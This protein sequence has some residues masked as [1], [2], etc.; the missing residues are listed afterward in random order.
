LLIILYVLNDE[1]EK[2][3]SGSEFNSGRLQQQRVSVRA[4][5]SDYARAE[6]FVLLPEKQNVADDRLLTPEGVQT[7]LLLQFQTYCNMNKPEAL[8]DKAEAPVLGARSE[9]LDDFKKD[10]KATANKILGAVGFF[11]KRTVAVAYEHTRTHTATTEFVAN[12]MADIMRQPCSALKKMTDLTILLHGLRKYI[13][14]R[15]SKDLRDLLDDALESLWAGTPQQGQEIYKDHIIFLYKDRIMFEA[16]FDKQIEIAQKLIAT[17]NTLVERALYEKAMREGTV[18]LMAGNKYN[19]Q[20][21]LYRCDE[22]GESANAIVLSSAAWMGD[23]YNAHLARLNVSHYVPIGETAEL[24]PRIQP[25]P[26]VVA[27]SSSQFF[28]ASQSRDDFYD[29]LSNYEPL[30]LFCTPPGDDSPFDRAESP[31]VYGVPPRNPYAPAHYAAAAPQSSPWI[32]QFNMPAAAP[33]QSGS[34]NNSNNDLRAYAP[35][36]PYTPL[37]SL[38]SGGNNNNAPAVAVDVDAEGWEVF[39][40]D[41]EQA[42]DFT[43]PPAYAPAPGAMAP[44]PSAPPPSVSPPPASSPSPLVNSLELLR[45]DKQEQERADFE[46]ARALARSS[47]LL[48]QV[49]A[50]PV[51][52]AAGA[53]EV[54]INDQLA[55]KLFESLNL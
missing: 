9:V 29:V 46:Y 49:Q 55:D 14:T 44:L 24:R 5:N 17:N 28:D 12:E 40:L 51:P 47:P 35:P 41:D 21:W 39:P 23:T 19:P 37:A 7:L 27:A 45:M 33:I 20:D 26:A 10:K 3:E 6:D 52:G 11:I 43:M 32:S 30:P 13:S 53:Q 16:K 48:S 31:P 2:M 50:I 18:P 34:A 1:E 4:D 36:P 42:A 15:N 25:T 8:K 38:G 54:D 22:V